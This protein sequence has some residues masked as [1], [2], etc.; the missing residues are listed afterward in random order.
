MSRFLFVTWDGGGNVPPLLGIAA[1]LKARGHAVLV[2]GDERQAGN[3]AAQ[4]VDFVAFGNAVQFDAS[5]YSD[6]AAFNTLRSRERG[7]RVIECLTAFPADVIVVDC[8]LFGVMG[9]PA[10]AKVRYV[11]LEHL[12]DAYLREKV[13]GGPFG[14]AAGLLGTNSGALLRNAELRLVASLPDLDPPRDNVIHIGPV[15]KGT[16]AR[17]MAPT[18]LVSLST[19]SYT[20]L[21]DT[22][23]RVLQAVDGV[24]ARVLATTG[25][26]I[27]PA[28]LSAPP[29]VE[30]YRW[31]PHAEILPS[32][33]MVVGHGGHATTMVALAHD[34]PI[35]VL[36]T[37]S[38]TDQPSVGAAIERAG[39]GLTMPRRSSPQKIR[40]AIED[41]LNGSS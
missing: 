9:V 4:K 17:A 37:H 6:L 31:L 32:V 36:P 30:L 33:S 28:S 29:D 21:R 24:S 27:D 7:R 20:G 34:L 38:M 22:W 35:L 18:I 40:T 19:V 16:P 11:V 26:G 41:L 23:R 13:V 8:M 25:P 12:F 1:E 3:I 10:Q 14:F 39:A 2:L 5:K 15:V